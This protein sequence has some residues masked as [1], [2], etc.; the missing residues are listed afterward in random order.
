MVATPEPSGARVNQEEGGAVRLLLVEP[1]P[2]LA[3]ALRIG[4]EEEGFAVHEVADRKTADE[5]LDE[6]GYDVIL[7]DLPGDFGLQTIRRWRLSGLPTPV[8]IVTEPGREGEP[9]REL[10]GNNLA[11]LNKPFVLEDLLARLRA[12]AQNS[13]NLHKDARL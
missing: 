10:P 8:L 9:R 13:G 11:T 7:L 2:L 5:A 1:H 12:L 3:R 4:L 6:S